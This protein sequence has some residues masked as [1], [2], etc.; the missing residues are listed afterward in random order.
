M[1]R[2]R[3]DNSDLRF[4]HDLLSY[5][6]RTTQNGTPV[7]RD[8]NGLGWRLRLTSPSGMVRYEKDALGRNA[9]IYEGTA[10]SGTIATYEY[11]GRDRVKRRGY[12]NGA[13]ESFDYDGLG[14][15]TAITNAVGTNVPFA[16]TRFALDANGMRRDI[17]YQGFGGRQGTYA[18][19]ISYDS[20]ARIVGISRSG[21][22]L[23]PG[24]AAAM[25]FEL[26]DA[27]NRISTKAGSRVTNYQSNANNQY[28]KVGTIPQ[29]YDVRGDLTSSDGRRY[30]YDYRHRLVEAQTSQGHVNFLYDELDRRIERQYTPAGGGPTEVTRYLYEG[31]RC[32]EEQDA[33]GATLA[34]YIHGNG[35]DEVVMMERGG[36]RYFYHHQHLGSVSHVTDDAGQVVEQYTYD[37]YGLPTIYDGAGNQRATSAIGNSILFTGRWYDPVLRLYDYRSRFYDPVTGQ[38]TTPDQAGYADGPNIYAYCKANPANFLDPFGEEAESDSFLEGLKDGFLATFAGGW[39]KTIKALWDFIKNAGEYWEKIKDLASKLSD[40]ETRA[41]IWDQL[42]AA[43]RSA[44]EDEWAVVEGILEAIKNGAKKLIG[45]ALGKLLGYL[46]NK[47]VSGGIAGKIAGIFGTISAKITGFLKGLAIAPFAGTLGKPKTYITYALVNKETDA[48]TYIG[49]AAG[50]GTAEDVM[51][52]RL[53][54]K[55]GFGKWKG[56]FTKHD[57]AHVGLKTIP[58]AVQGSSDASKGAEE[59]FYRFFKDFKGGAL[60]NKIPPRTNNVFDWFRIKRAKGVVQTYFDDLDNGPGKTLPDG[61]KLLRGF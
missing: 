45:A 29:S 17:D 43:L 37:L 42:K 13:H 6:V 8:V 59:V 10:L 44:L 12:G 52:Q 61:L 4:E 48:V 7:E 26:D 23:P 53:G 50:Y 11:R 55:I 41:R 58:I 14:R 33:Q 60:T 34:R 40:P 21:P 51:K 1:T 24:L 39:G 28:T 35:I 19:K 49:K 36:R 25:S 3:N 9:A 27:D 15:L 5:L 30:I 20:I 38:F 18:E 16:A 22:A 46:L 54:S 47:A 32:I 31:F 57:H 56:W 2:L